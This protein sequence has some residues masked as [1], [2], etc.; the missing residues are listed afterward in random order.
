VNERLLQLIWQHGMFQPN[1]LHTTDGEPV[2]IV[3]RGKLNTNQGPDFLEGRV[4]IGTT[5]LVGNIELHL[6][7]SDWHKHGHQ[8]DAN[9]QNLILHVVLE[10]DSKEK[11]PASIPVLEL[12]HY[13][14]KDAEERYHQLADNSYQLPCAK[15]HAGVKFITK[16]AWMTRLLAERWEQKLSEWN[17]L[18]QN[19]AEDWRN[20][21]YWRLAYNF[22]FK[23]NAEPFFLLARSLP[24]NILARHKDVPEQADALL[25]GQAG[26]L[27]GTFEDT[28]PNDLQKEYAFLSRKYNLKP[29]PG[30]LWKFLRMRPANFPTLRIAQFSML[31]Q[32]SAHLFTQIIATHS[33]RDIEPLLDV[34]AGGYWDTHFRFDEVQ[35]KATPKTLGKSS[36]HNIIINTIAPIQ[37]L[38]AS[39]QDTHQQR[40]E[41]IQLLE[42]LPPEANK[43]IALW[44]NEGWHASSAAQTQALIQLYNNYCSSKRC[45]DC[46]VGIEILK[47]TPVKQ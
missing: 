15:L 13:I 20:L 44:E 26:M 12:K 5:T 24:L 19:S 29:I 6:K 17:I 22:G 10:N 46:A 9:Y 41:A 18:L 28:Y 36:V 27:H 39:K 16:E 21:L 4:K 34:V 35:K 11:N 23:V 31:I 40:E 14:K 1:D 45:F 33:V 47:N 37:Y 25:F 38:Y 3:S 7:T 30:H 32:K 43:I 8:N 2:S 42:A